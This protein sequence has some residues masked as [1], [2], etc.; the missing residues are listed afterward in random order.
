MTN[1]IEPTIFSLKFSLS[2]VFNFKR[3][4]CSRYYDPGVGRFLQKDPD[5][6][7]LENPMTVINTFA[8]AVNNPLK[9]RDPTGKWI[10]IAAA[11]GALIGAIDASLHHENILAGA[12]K[13][14]VAGMLINLTWNFS[15]STTWFGLL[16]APQQWAGFIS[17]IA[18]PTIGAASQ[19]GS[20]VNNLIDRTL[21]GHTLIG[22][23][24]TQLDSALETNILKNAWTEPFEYAA[25]PIIIGTEFLVTRLPS[26][27]F[28]EEL[29]NGQRNK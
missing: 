24:V 2:E 22:A 21:R 28:E 27:L 20:F 13:G 29:K 1:C 15:A 14:A 23:S 8:Y 19:G 6:G 11:I 4:A 18:G 5:P 26:Y 9:Y 3:A 25:Y 16:E 7:K 12:F 17:A 10:W